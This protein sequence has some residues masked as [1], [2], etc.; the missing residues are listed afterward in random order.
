MNTALIKFQAA[1][2]DPVFGTVVWLAKHTEVYW[3]T[4]WARGHALTGVADLHVGK[5]HTTLTSKNLH[6]KTQRNSY[7]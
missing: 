6:A 1:A 5:P 3:E 2:T 4:N 7:M